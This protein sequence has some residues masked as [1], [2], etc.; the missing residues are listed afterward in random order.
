[1][2]NA[3]L[4]CSFAACFDSFDFKSA[5]K[6]FGKT[7][8]A[9]GCRHAPYGNIDRIYTLHTESDGSDRNFDGRN[10]FHSK[11]RRDTYYVFSGA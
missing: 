3:V 4:Q 1:M 2:K 8:Y 11:A 5:L 7:Q 10:R 6:A 9:A